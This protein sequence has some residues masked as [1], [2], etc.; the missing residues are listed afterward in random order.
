MV[1]RKAP[2]LRR[3]AARSAGPAPE[4]KRPVGCHRCVT[5]GTGAGQSG[6]GEPARRGSR[7]RRCVARR[8]G[9]GAL[10]AGA[11]GG[12]VPR[13]RPAGGRRRA[14]GGPAGHPDVGGPVRRA[15][16]RQC[17]VAGLVRGPLA[18]TQG[19]GA[20]T[21]RLRRHAAVP[22]HPR[23]AP[24][25]PV[26]ARGERQ[27]RPAVHLSRLR[28]ALLRRRPPGAG[29]GRRPGRRRR[30]E[31]PGSPAPGHHPAGGGRLSR[32]GSRGAGRGVH[33][34]HPVRPRRP[35]RRR[36]GRRLGRR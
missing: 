30:G 35:P 5:A 27:D 7:P 23:R 10:A 11:G 31:R 21:R 15:G 14:P 6:H 25:G 9:A 17:R 34:L 29:G 4:P 12:P 13:R 19:A 24:A 22:A 1:G 33:A 20:G 36:P 26:P 8:P 16:W 18:R 32:D 2:A 3:R 28:H